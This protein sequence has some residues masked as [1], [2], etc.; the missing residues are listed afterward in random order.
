VNKSNNLKREA[1]YHRQFTFKF[2]Q[3]FFPFLFN[4]IKH[5]QQLRTRTEI[6]KIIAL[7]LHTYACILNESLSSSLNASANSLLS[8]N[9]NT[10]V[11]INL[12]QSDNLL[13]AITPNIVEFLFN[14][15]NEEKK[16]N[17]NSNDDDEF[18]NKVDELKDLDLIRIRKKLF[19]DKK[20]IICR[21]LPSIINVLHLSLP[22]KRLVDLNSVF[23]KSINSME[24]INVPK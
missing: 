22:D 9:S 14:L 21:C 10:G 2:D 20:L 23:D 24:E 15:L 1:N 17:S 8:N 4:S 19:Y 3:S 7:I 11:L 18:Y 12:N 5:F 6:I 16:N 13:Q